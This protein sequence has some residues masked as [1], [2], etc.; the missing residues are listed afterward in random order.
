MKGFSWA[1]TGG[2]ECA[3]LG[4]VSP[5]RIRIEQ[6]ARFGDSALA[7]EPSASLRRK[8]DANFARPRSRQA[9]HA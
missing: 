9:D 3:V 7:A 4:A 2:D 6:M 5:A 1:G 8:P